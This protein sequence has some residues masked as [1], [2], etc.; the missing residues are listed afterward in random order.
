MAKSIINELL[1]FRSLR[2]IDYKKSLEQY[3]P[4]TLT[5]GLA[6]AYIK[7][8]RATR[9][10]FAFQLEHDWLFIPG[11]IRHPLRLIVDVMNATQMDHLRFNKKRNVVGRWD[12]WLKEFE[13]YPGFKCCETPIRSNN[14]HIIDTAQ[15]RRTILKFIRTNKSSRGGVEDALIR[16][17]RKP[18]QRWVHLWTFQP[19]I[20]NKAFGRQGKQEKS[21][22]LTVETYQL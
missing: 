10:Q 18:N 4:V 12:R 1:S 17:Q 15:Y 9:T 16:A 5:S 14:P 20:H 11:R 19:F 21:S 22:S 3:C 2:L 8:I 7:S 6:D 13:P